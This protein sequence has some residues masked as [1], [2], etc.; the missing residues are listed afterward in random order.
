MIGTPNNGSAKSLVSTHEGFQFSVVF[1]SFP[2]GLVASLPSIYQLLPSGPEPCVFDSETGEPLDHFD[3]DT[4]DER[5]WGMLNPDQ[6]YVLQQLLPDV[7]SAEKRREF[8]K[9]HV[10]TC[11]ERAYIFQQ[12]LNYKASPPEGT[13]LHL[14]A[15]DAI[16]TAPL[17]IR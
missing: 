8:A 2:S 7:E 3:V 12:A 16:P 15:G 9:S 14:F 1:D 11:L 5:G 4:W 17:P 6:D 10:Q 13:T